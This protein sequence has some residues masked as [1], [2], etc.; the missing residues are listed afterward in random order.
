MRSL[1][2]GAN[3]QDGSYLCGLLAASG[4]EVIGVGRQRNAKYDEANELYDYRQLDLR[5]AVTLT[6]LL[7]DFR[8]VEIYHFAA[9]HGAAGYAYEPAWGDA[10]DVNVKVLHTCLEYARCASD[11]VKIFYPSSA[12]VFGSPL[13]ELVSI[14][15]PKIATCLYSTSKICAENFFHAEI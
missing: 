2:L 9:V 4:A 11:T 1:V 12:K 5:D 8:P 6:K 14:N 15:S 10:L 7:N 13:P 3:G